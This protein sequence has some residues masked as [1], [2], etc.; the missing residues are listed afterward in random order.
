LYHE[1]IIFVTIIINIYKNN[2]FFFK[3]KKNNTKY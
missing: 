3:E 1:H 2:Q